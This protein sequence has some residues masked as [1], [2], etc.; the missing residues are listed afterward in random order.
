MQQKD[1]LSSSLQIF[2]DATYNKNE[3][4]RISSLFATVLSYLSSKPNHVD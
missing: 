1:C 4:F 3:F 2:S